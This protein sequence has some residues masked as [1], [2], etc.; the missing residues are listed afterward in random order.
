MLPERG[1][2][3]GWLALGSHGGGG[4][5]FDVM[6]RFPEAVATTCDALED[7]E[8]RLTDDDSLL[9]P[10]AAQR[11]RIETLRDDIEVAL[12][13]PRPDHRPPHKRKRRRIRK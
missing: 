1:K 5:W 4:Y 11:Q 10:L 7:L 6:S 2:R 8:A 9:E 13:A 12:S 3:P